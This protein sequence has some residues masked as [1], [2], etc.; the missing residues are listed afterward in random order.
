MLQIY[1]VFSQNKLIIAEVILRDDYLDSHIRQ[2]ISGAERP[3]LIT[4]RTKQ[5]KL[6]LTRH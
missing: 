6:R 1:I 5:F 3:S 4:I 2:E